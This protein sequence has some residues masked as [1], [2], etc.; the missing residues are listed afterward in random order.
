[1][2]LITFSYLMM[3]K[4][5]NRYVWKYS[6]WQKSQPYSGWGESPTLSVLFPVTSANVRISPQ[7]I[8]TFSFNPFATLV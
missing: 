4:E 6:V 3:F 8:L 5:H 2:P 7:N 1:M